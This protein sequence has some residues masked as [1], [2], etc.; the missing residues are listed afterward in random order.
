MSQTPD[1]ATLFYLSCPR[2]VYRVECLEI[3]HPALPSGIYRFTYSDI[4]GV[5][6][7]HEDG[8]KHY[9]QYCPMSVK[10]LSRRTDLQ[11]GME[12]TVGD[13]GDG[14]PELL[15]K[16]EAAGGMDEP[17]VCVY[18]S[19]RSDKLNTV[20]DGPLEYGIDQISRD[21]EASTFEVRGRPMNYSGTG[22]YY[23]LDEFQLRGFI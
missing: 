6:V 12:V 22:R 16:I 8:Q 10:P 13:I 14:I 3:W 11:T 9:Y 20:I 18:R 5:T 7:T 2:S 17:A 23:D 4:D 1:Q 19:Y 15:N 21:E